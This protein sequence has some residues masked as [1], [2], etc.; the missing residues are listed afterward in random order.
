[1]RDGRVFVRKFKQERFEP[2]KLKITADRVYFKK[3]R[4]SPRGIFYIAP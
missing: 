1:M 4:W 2:P 3:Y